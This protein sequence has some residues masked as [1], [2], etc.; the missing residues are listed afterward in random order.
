MIN[1]NFDSLYILGKKESV[2]EQGIQ[3]YD[4]T[5]SVNEIDEI[6]ISVWDDEQSLLKWKETNLID[7]EY[8]SIDYNSFF[9]LILV[10]I[11]IKW[12]LLNPLP[13]M[14][15]FKVAESLG[16]KK[17]M[18]LSANESWVFLEPHI[19]SQG[20]SN[21][22]FN[23]IKHLALELPNLTPAD[24]I[25]NMAE[26]LEEKISSLLV[27]QPNE[28]QF[29]NDH[30]LR[31]VVFRNIK[32]FDGDKKIVSQFDGN[33]IHDARLELF[34]HCLEMIVGTAKNIVLK[35]VF[36]PTN[37]L[38]FHSN[39]LEGGNKYIVILGV[40][41]SLTLT[42]EV[43]QECMMASDNISMTFI[44]SSE[45]IDLL[46]AH[47]HEINTYIPA[48]RQSFKYKVNSIVSGLLDNSELV[49]M[50]ENF[51][52]ELP[53]GF[54]TNIDFLILVECLIEINNSHLGELLFLSSKETRCFFKKENLDFINNN[55]DDV[56]SYLNDRIRI[57]T[58][59]INE[60]ITVSDYRQEIFVTYIFI[61]NIVINFFAKKWE[62]EFKDYFNN[63]SEL[64]LD[65]AIERYCSIDTVVH[66]NEDSIS[67]FL[68]Y[69]IKNG[70]FESTSYINCLGI[71]NPILNKVMKVKKNFNF[72]NRLKKTSTNNQ[73]KYSIDDVD[74]MNG[75]E[76]ESFIAVLFSKMG[77]ESEVTKA[78]GD[79]GIDVIAS[80]N[81]NTIGIQAK[82]YSGSVGNGAIQ[83]VVAGKNHY[84]LD[85]A[86]VVTNNVFTISAQQLAQSNSIVLWDRTI[87]KE[88]IDEIFNS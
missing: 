52:N 48:L 9:K 82:C 72:I 22:N 84:R 26:L 23:S 86:I 61:Y 71:F 51:I 38:E 41:V 18:L 16:V 65:E 67:S 17:V 8:C 33:T 37:E 76:F 57:F 42:T 20:L 53:V 45:H 68:Y 58:L 79:Q 78:S 34:G 66:Q 55:E 46:K 75:L 62:N 35:A 31:H 10:N 29:E 64:N 27:D 74:L 69:L 6:Y 2:D 14:E 77:Y 32:Y 12:A 88:K 44:M 43:N 47:Y 81:G 85:K 49:E 39:L 21:E 63:I 80:R 60:H 28:E 73:K 59:I 54:Y 4:L 36:D 15:D 50:G 30:K 13:E 7:K 87:L 5:C 40:P 70:K 83:E 24:F 3:T 25:Y 19:Y 56:V 1:F 11:E